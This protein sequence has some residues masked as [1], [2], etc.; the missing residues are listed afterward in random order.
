MTKR[1]FTRQKPVHRLHSQP[2][3]EQEIP[4]SLLHTKRYPTR[5][6]SKQARLAMSPK[7]KKPSKNFSQ[8]KETAPVS[9]TIPRKADKFGPCAGWQRKTW[10]PPWKLTV[11]LVDLQNSLGL[12]SCHG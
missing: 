10:N 2:Q 4:K 9:L 3:I 12:P 7:R 5:N 1:R 11:A 6:P 8:Q